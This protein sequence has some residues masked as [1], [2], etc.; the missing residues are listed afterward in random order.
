MHNQQLDPVQDM[1]NTSMLMNDAS[2]PAVDGEQV[3]TLVLDLPARLLA[4]YVKAPHAPQAL[5]LSY[6]CSCCIALETSQ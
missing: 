6:V 3:A 1:Y 4:H 2:K 5:R